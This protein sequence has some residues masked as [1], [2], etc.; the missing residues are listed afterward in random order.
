[1]IA[2]LM[3]GR[4]GSVGFPGKNT[5]PVLGRPMAVY[6]MR[7]ARASQFV[8]RVYLST[9][10]EALMAL[11]RQEGVEVIV[12]PPHL[13]TKQALGEDAYRHGYGV[14][15]DQAA[16]QG[17]TLEML[18]LLFCNAPTVNAALIDQGIAALRAQPTYDSAVTVSCYNMWSPLRA[19]RETPE[20]L[21][22][23]FVPFETFG[24]PKTLNC[25][26]DSQGDVWFADMSLSVVRP[27]CFEH[28]EDGLLPQKWMGRRIY[29]IKQWGG[30]DVDAEW[31]I[32]QVEFWLRQHGVTPAEDG[33]R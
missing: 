10:D 23:P 5:F 8:D 2:A 26:R 18:A 1:M 13:A 22:E 28:M 6:P 19:R 30:L 31:Q 33:G 7:A 21:L 27:R 12:R 20:G 17:R 25:D 4:K 24:D 14:I 15:R 32:P 9:D 11:A 29:P 16:A 3:L